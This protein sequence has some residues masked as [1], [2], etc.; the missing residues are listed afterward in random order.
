MILIA[1]V[2][3]D[4]CLSLQGFFHIE[5]EE[6]INTLAFKISFW[7]QKQITDK[8]WKTFVDVINMI[9]FAKR[10]IIFHHTH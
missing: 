1:F 3:Q 10:V 5:Y 6:V 9:K 4:P 8:E 7:W 2:M